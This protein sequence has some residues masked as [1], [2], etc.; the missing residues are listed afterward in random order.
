MSPLLIRLI[1]HAIF[2][3]NNYEP[4]LPP[5]TLTLREKTGQRN[6]FTL[7][8]ILLTTMVLLVGLSV[9]FHTT[10]SALQ[11]LSAAREQAEI[12]NTCQ[13]ILHE[14]LAQSAPI[15]PDPGKTIP[16]LPHWKIRIDLYPAPQ[17]RLYVLHLSAQQFSPQ[18]NLLLGVHYHLIRW[19]PIERVWFPPIQ[20]EM[21]EGSE[22]EVW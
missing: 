18:D 17:S 9:V 22:F 3:P 1:V 15:R 7:F 8:E 14:L 2:S 10:R 6:G 21:M 11:R 13:T 20:Q 16:H 5:E 12:Q 19:I 4:L